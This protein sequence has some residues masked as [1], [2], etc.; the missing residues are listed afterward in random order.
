VM[1]DASL[2]AMKTTAFATSSALA[3]RFESQ[4][5]NSLAGAQLFIEPQ[6]GFGP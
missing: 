3:I 1:K 5:F 4:L 6:P 2:D